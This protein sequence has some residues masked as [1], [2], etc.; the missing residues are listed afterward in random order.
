[1]TLLEDA[2]FLDEDILIYTDSDYSINCLTKWIP[3]WISRGWKTSDG[4]DVLHQDMIRDISERLARFKG[5]RFIHVKAHTGAQDDLSRNNDVVDRMAR[6][7]IDE[8]V[9]VVDPPVVD[10]I[11]PGCPLRLLGPPTS[12]ADIL[13]WMYANLSTL[14]KDVVDKHMMK[15]FVEICKAR[16]VTLT[17]QT[18]QRAPM[19]RAE[20][21]HLQ[22]D[23]IVVE[24]IE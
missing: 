10:D 11:F 15:A 22:I 2:G 21:G 19:Y 7:T 23:H 8:T 1:V 12:Q 13:G 24:K 17:K 4:K 16:D 5:H 14:D 6:G 3:G 20:R 18:I 9:R